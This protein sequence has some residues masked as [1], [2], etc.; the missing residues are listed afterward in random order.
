MLVLLLL[1]QVVVTVWGISLL[2]K[3]VLLLMVLLPSKIVASNS[4]AETMAQLN[5]VITISYTEK[6]KLSRHH[7]TVYHY[8]KLHSNCKAIRHSKYTHVWVKVGI[9]SR[10]CSTTNH[11]HIIFCGVWRKWV[12]GKQLWSSFLALQRLAEVY[13]CIAVLFTVIIICSVAEFVAMRCVPMES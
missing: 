8:Q 4:F 10:C 9:I 7:M 5:L 6:F 1:L 11:R 12:C 13:S 3:C 2:F